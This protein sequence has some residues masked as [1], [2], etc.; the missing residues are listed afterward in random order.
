MASDVELGGGP[1]PD[2]DTRSAPGPVAPVCSPAWA[3]GRPAGSLTRPR[4]ET[5]YARLVV[6]GDLLAVAIAVLVGHL[7]GL[8]N[9]LP[10]FGGST[11]PSL[12]IGSGLI[13]VTGL[14]VTRAW[15]PRILGQG[16]DEFSRVLHALVASAVVVGL[17]GLALQIS[18]VRPWVFGL[19]PLAG[20][21]LV[22]G[23]FVLRGWLHRRRADG[24]FTHAVLAVGTIDSVA[25]L[26]RR[27]R[28][29]SHNGWVVNGVCTPTGAGADG[30]PSVLDVPVLGDLD[31]VAEIVRRGRHRVVAVGD[32]PGWSGRRLHQ[33]A[34]DI[35]GLGADLV[36]DPGLMEIAGPRLHV[37]PVDGLPLLRLT[38]PIFN[39]VPRV[40]KNV[41]DWVGASLLLVVVAPVLVCIAVAVKLDGGPVLFRQTRVGRHGNA[42]RMLK[43]RSMIVDAEACKADLMAA[44][45]G[46]GPLFKL[47]D[48]PRV[49]K[50]G[51]FLRKYSLDELPQLVNVLT[52]SMSL[53]G[54]RPPLPQEVATYSRAAERKLLVKPGLTG[55][56]QISGRSDLSWQESVRLDLRY[57]ENWT[58]AMDAHILWK[59]LGALIRGNG[60]Y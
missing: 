56:W 28:R 33:L 48:D 37:A 23:R 41:I 15:D 44:N 14:F 46:A 31:S 36:V 58:L 4:W 19:I 7:L 30:T 32:A 40:V 20:I 50:I 43:F 11:S 42:F 16:S 51:A 54:P 18:A 57:V 8:G 5:R 34:W 38:E 47:K 3:V 29:D 35:E 52:G 49:T 45:D 39:G 26:I 12:G 25:D 13:T 24:R 59:T 2:A 1:E 27:T 21:L 22:I 53:V 9:Y 6:G 55:L 60:A 10:L 17:G